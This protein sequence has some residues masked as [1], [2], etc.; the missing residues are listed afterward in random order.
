ML[1]TL[2]NISVLQFPNMEV[3]IEFTGLYIFHK[4]EVS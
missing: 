2:F 3:I 1:G 4:D